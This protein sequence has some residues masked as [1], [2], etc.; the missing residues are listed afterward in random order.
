MKRE[1]ADRAARDPAH[2]DRG[3][4][5]PADGGARARA[6]HRGDRAGRG[7][8]A[9]LR[10][11]DRALD[12]DGRA[13]GAVGA[14]RGGR[15]RAA[16]RGV[17]R[18]AE[19][20]GDVAGGIVYA[21]VFLAPWLL[22]AYVVPDRPSRVAEAQGG[23][24]GRGEGVARSDE[25][26]S[27]QER[28]RSGGNGRAASGVSSAWSAHRCSSWE[29]EPQ[30]SWPGNRAPGT[31]ARR[32]PKRSSGRA[33]FGRAR[34]R[35]GRFR[36]VRAPPGRDRLAGSMARGLPRHVDP[37]R[38][39]D[40]PLRRGR[41][42]VHAAVTLR[43]RRPCGQDG[44]AAVDVRSRAVRRTDCARV[45]DGEHA[46]APSMNATRGG[47]SA[48]SSSW[49]RDVRAATSGGTRDGPA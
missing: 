5:R 32:A 4:R 48:R 16:D 36:G 2:A 25:R 33:P 42:R 21:T 7:R 17:P 37:S 15:V 43:S 14:R 27:F 26:D 40:R 29:S 41:R 22:V 8:A 24:G 19:G 38:S 45:P 6:P 9:L 20:A 28:I 39:A 23:A 35:L 1:T 47:G 3:P 46:G 49:R 18:F 44:T 10:P 34:A 13:A 12:A 11:A 31:L 30:R